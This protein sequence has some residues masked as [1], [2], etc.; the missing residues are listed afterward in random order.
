MLL[1]QGYDFF[2]F[3]TVLSFLSFKLNEKAENA[4]TKLHKM[5]VKKNNVYA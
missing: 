1:L 5:C 2:F 4:R 3:F